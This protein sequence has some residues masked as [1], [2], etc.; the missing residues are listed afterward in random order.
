VLVVFGLL[1]WV[2]KQYG[3]ARAPLILGFILGRL[4]EKYLFI[5]VGRYEFEWLQRPGVIAIFTVTVLVLVRPLFTAFYKMWKQAGTP[6]DANLRFGGA[7]SS[8]PLAPRTPP[9]APAAVMDAAPA[10]AALRTLSIEQFLGP[11]LWV[12]AF[13]GFAAAFWSATGWRFSARLMPQTAAAAG[14]IVIVCAGATVVLAK[15]QGRPIL[16][17]KTAYE[18]MGAFGELTE[19]TVYARLVVEALWLV[20][21]LI[22]VVLIGLMPAM[23]LY[24]FLYMSTA[25]KTR[26]PT[27]LLITVSLWIGF[28]ILFV[29]LLHVPWPPSL[30]G[31]AFPDLR[32]WTGRLI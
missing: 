12:I 30:L 14:L 8:S 4:I 29:M 15:L 1:G 25:G 7:A 16:Q 3:W 9:P 27:A 5:S 23:G 10:S 24:M 32:E 21:F 20:G 6:I 28:Y 2:M 11:G 17:S 31:D 22:G 19:K 13:L 26:W 18:V